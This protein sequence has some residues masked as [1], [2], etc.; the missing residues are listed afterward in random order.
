MDGI[1]GPEVVRLVIIAVVLLVGLGV[2]RF[3][4]KMTKTAMQVG[5]ALILFVVAA[6]FVLTIL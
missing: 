1:M 2:L 6:I 5:C 4:F 3:L